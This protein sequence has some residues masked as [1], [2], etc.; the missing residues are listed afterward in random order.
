MSWNT[1]D[2]NQ[3]IQELKKFKEKSNSISGVKDPYIIIEKKYYD[4][5]YSDLSFFNKFKSKLL[6]YI[7]IKKLK[8]QFYIAKEKRSQEIENKIGNKELIIFDSLVGKRVR[9]KTSGNIYLI[10]WQRQTENHIL[11]KI[12]IQEY[13]IDE[14]IKFFDIEDDS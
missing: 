6:G 9:S 3:I 14:V 8:I 11:F 1:K 5:I 7:Y 12:H 2:S 4:K 10:E 13:S